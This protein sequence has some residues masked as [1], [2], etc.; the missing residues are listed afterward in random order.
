M[1]W[2]EPLRGM[3]LGAAACLALSGCFRP[4]Y[5]PTASGVP[6]GDVLRSIDVAQIITP[7]GQ[8]RLGHNIRSELI[9]DLDGS[10]Q[11]HDKKYRIEIEASEVVQ[12][13]TTNVVT[14]RA[15]AALLNVSARFNLF[16]V[17]GR[18]VVLAG[19]SRASATYFRDPQR[20]ADVRAA[21]DAEIRASKQIAEDIKQ[22][23]AAILATAP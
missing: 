8:E 15:D 2:S 1:S 9:F 21:R 5:G 6:L 10:G 4:L 14:G 3:L 18:K 12:V 20:F 17:E 7:P 11:T 16:N 19:T 13:T 23:A 22:R